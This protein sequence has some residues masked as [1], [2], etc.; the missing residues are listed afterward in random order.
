MAIEPCT[1]HSGISD[2]V[3][4]RVWLP[5]LEGTGRASNIHAGGR[6]AIAGMVYR[7]SLHDFTGKSSSRLVPDL[8]LAEEPHESSLLFSCR[9]A[10]SIISKKEHLCHN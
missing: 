2:I 6:L 4:W 5:F 7:S 1:L 9:G 3:R 8:R 10:S